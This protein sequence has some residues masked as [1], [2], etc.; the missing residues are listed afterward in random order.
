VLGTFGVVFLILA[1]RALADGYITADYSGTWDEAFVRDLSNPAADT[2]SMHFVW[3]ERETA[4]VFGG[5][6][7]AFATVKVLS[8]KLT[9]T[10]TMTKSYAPPN[11][12][13]SCSGSFSIRPGG[14]FPLFVSAGFFSNP[15]MSNSAIVPLGGDYSQSN[16]P[17][18]CSYP[19]NGSAGITEG[20]LRTT[21]YTVPLTPLFEFKLSRR[22][23]KKT[24][25]TLDLSTDGTYQVA[26]HAT[27]RA[28]TS[29][30][31]PPPCLRRP[32]WRRQSATRS[33]ATRS[34]RCAGR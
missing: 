34:P 20:P 13:L 16:G 25:K 33:S 7:S 22:Q 30:S 17:P 15:L 6:P 27:F 24:F 2:E 28:A 31:K 12:A 10:G 8:R 32:R 14:K 9:I 11:A 18:N 3:D 19:V 1:G 4:H 21:N 26:V 5:T 23:Y 29:A